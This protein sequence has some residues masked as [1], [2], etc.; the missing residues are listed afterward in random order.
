MVAVRIVDQP[1]T[2]LG[3]VTEVA[4]REGDVVASICGA[5]YRSHPT[6]TSIQIADD[7]HMDGLQVVAYLN[8]SCDPGTYVDVR[9]LTVIAARNLVPGDA[10]TFFYPSTEWAMACPFVCACASDGCLGRVHGAQRVP[11]AVLS[12]YR[13][14]AHIRELVTVR[15]AAAA[16]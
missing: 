8:H 16:P 14:S 3:L 12:R 2:G 4:L 7:R 6:R 11:T 15:D 10:L 1:G 13:L 5:E 9:A